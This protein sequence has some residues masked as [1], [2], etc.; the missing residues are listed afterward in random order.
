MLY[1]IFLKIILILLKDTP[2]NSEVLVDLKNIES[3]VYFNTFD[4]Y[5]RNLKD[6]W[7][8][9][10]YLEGLDQW[11]KRLLMQ[12]KPVNQAT[13]QKVQVY[14]HTAQKKLNQESYDK[15]FLV[16]NLI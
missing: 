1:K 9:W 2:V 4:Y 13:Y 5:L 12:R 8:P 11:S 6:I 7:V 16:F 14:I 15:S 3:P 10:S